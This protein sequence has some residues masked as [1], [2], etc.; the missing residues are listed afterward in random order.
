MM[1]VLHP[2]VQSSRCGLG[3]LG[4]GDSLLGTELGPTLVTTELV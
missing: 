2:M 4:L 3:L 1:H